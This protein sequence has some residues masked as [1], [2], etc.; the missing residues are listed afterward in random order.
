MIMSQAI[1]L[2]FAILILSGVTISNT[3]AQIIADAMGEVAQEPTEWTYEVKKLDR[4]E[5]E[6]VFHAKLK[7]GW[8]IF[9]QNPG[10]SS[11]IAPTFSFDDNTAIRRLGELKEKG[12]LIETTFEGFD[13]KLRYFEGKVEFI[14]KISYLGA[15][16]TI[17]GEHRYQLCND[18]MC[19]PP[20]SKKFEFVTQK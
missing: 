4:N 17:T 1:K 14:Q 16:T 20:T 19:L 9:S 6:L 18:N 10:D 13:N 8:H 11:L 2:I 15:S 5:Y 12:K 3:Q 7:K